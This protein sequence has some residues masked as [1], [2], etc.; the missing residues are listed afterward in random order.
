MR[1]KKKTR[2]MIKHLSQREKLLLRKRNKRKE[3][4]TRRQQQ[5]RQ[6]L[7]LQLQSQ[8][9]RHKRKKQRGTTKKPKTTTESESD[10]DYSGDYENSE[11]EKSGNTSRL[12]Q[13]I[14]LILASVLTFLQTLKY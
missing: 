5:Q 8:Q 6:P 10:E 13:P 12:Q 7:Q 4:R 3:K 11:P 9:Q 2:K 1:R 14:F